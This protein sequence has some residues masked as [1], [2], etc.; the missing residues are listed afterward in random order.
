LRLYQEFDGQIDAPLDLAGAFGGMSRF[1][2][3]PDHE[4]D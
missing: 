3:A 2:A 4:D 1:A